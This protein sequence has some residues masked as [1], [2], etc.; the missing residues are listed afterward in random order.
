MN[1]APLSDET[2]DL[3]W[4]GTLR[5]FQKKRGYRF[6]IDAVLL[7]QFIKMRKEEKAIDLGTGCGILPLL[8]SRTTKGTSFVGIEI[9]K[10][11]VELANKNVLSNHLQDRIV[12]LH[13]DYKNAKKHFSP[14]SFDVVFSNPPYRKSLTGRMNPSLEKAIARHEIKGTLEELIG[15]I[16]YLLP[17]KGRCYLIYP[18]TRMVDLIEGL[19]NEKVEPKRL[20]LVYPSLDKEAKFVLIEAI[21]SSGVTLEVIPPQVL[22]K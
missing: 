19:R 3:F 12:I 11:L 22:P 13:D 1:P 14:G 2:L 10:E 6:S 15:T 8:L 17:T 5:I 20:Q 4:G 21:K 7:S 18:A 16:S 9:Q